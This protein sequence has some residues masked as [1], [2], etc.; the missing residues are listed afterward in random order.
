MGM[1]QAGML[2]HASCFAEMLGMGM[3]Q[4]GMLLH[5]S[6]FAEMSGMGMSQAQ[7]HKQAKGSCM[8][9][10]QSHATEA[11]QLNNWSIEH[12][13]SSIIFGQL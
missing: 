8:Q 9:H 1:S 2:L 12:R 11:E 10:R 3:S 13:K 4:V 5:A 6:C 7:Y